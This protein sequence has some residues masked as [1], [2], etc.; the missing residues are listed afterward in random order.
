MNVQR[1]ILRSAIRF[2]MVAV[3]FLTGAARCQQH[4]VAEQ[5][6]F[7][8]INEERAAAGLSPLAWSQPLQ[9]A[10]DQHARR[11][12]ASAI[13][14]HR[15]RG[16]AEL[17]E[18]ASASGNDFPLVTE[19]VGEGTSPI[20]L[21]AALM[22]SPHHRENILDPQVNAI[23]IAVVPYRG[24]LWVVEDF[25]YRV[26][27]LP[28]EEQERLVTSLLR[29]A[30]LSVVQPTLQARTICT[31]E[32]GFV[33]ARPAFIMRYV[34]NGMTYLP[35]ELSQRMLEGGISRAEVGACAP[36]GPNESV[37]Y[38]LAVVLYR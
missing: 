13:L 12:G 4:T 26:P 31:M 21:H 37:A 35:Q 38:R 18:R 14:S 10:A 16:E 30:G 7:S 28:V 1:I 32:T 22:Q 23:G 9:T 17:A 15:L 25:A 20:D 29:H 2:A 19:N 8:A 6:L 5:Y 33:G 24:E 11:M 3:L 27:F 34:A 36:V